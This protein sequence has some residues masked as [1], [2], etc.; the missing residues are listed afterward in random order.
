LPSGCHLEWQAAKRANLT[1]PSPLLSSPFLS[2]IFL[3]SPLH[4]SLIQP[5]FPVQPLS[6]FALWYFLLNIP[7]KLCKI[8]VLHAE[9]TKERERKMGEKESELWSN[10]NVCTSV[11]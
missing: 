3:S 5:Q 2:L 7:N 9:T 4:C 10:Q 6:V 8:L 1:V 11:E